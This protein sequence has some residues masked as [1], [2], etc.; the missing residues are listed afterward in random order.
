MAGFIQT[1]NSRKV[2]VSKGSSN[3][4]SKCADANFHT[5]FAVCVSAAKYV[6]PPLL[7]IPGKLLNQDVL[8]VCNIEG[9]NIKTP[10]KDFIN[11]TLF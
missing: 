11:Y 6:A 1:K 3:V 10:P 2:V 7:I 8:E 9:A 5:T 4:W